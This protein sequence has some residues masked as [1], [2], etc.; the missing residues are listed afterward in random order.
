MGREL[1]A[2]D[3]NEFILLETPELLQ[4]AMQN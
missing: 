2:Q 4:Q 3:H 1:G